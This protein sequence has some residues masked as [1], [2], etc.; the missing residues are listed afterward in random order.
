MLRRA[1]ILRCYHR[2]MTTDSGLARGVYGSR[3]AAKLA[4]VSLRQLRYWVSKGLIRPSIYRAGRDGRDLFSYTDLV[5]A[6][7]I[8]KLR[9]GKPAASLRTITRA[10]DYLRAELPQSPNWHEKT[11]VM[12]SGVLALMDPGEVVNTTHAS[13]GQR[14]FTVTLGEL[15]RELLHV[16]EGLGIGRQL[17]VDRAVLGGSPVIRGTRIPTRLIG[18]LLAEGVDT[19]GITRLYPGVSAKAISAAKEFERQLAAV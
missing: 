3:L 2:R 15:T 7:V 1:P 10:L 18:E 16:S 19:E 11:L 13:P 6:R 8:G 9:K 4:G 17:E 12:S 14:V 5:Q